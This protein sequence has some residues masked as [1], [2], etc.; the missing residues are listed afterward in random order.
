MLKYIKQCLSE[1][2]EVVAAVVVLVGEAEVAAGAVEALAAAAEGEVV[3]A[4][5]EAGIR[6][7]QSL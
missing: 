3:E 7:H 6:D 2:E 4:A 1:A 5:A